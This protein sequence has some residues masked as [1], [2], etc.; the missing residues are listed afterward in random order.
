MPK[1]PP[2]LRP[3]YLSVFVGGPLKISAPVAAVA[4]LV[5]A[6]VPGLALLLAPA[7][8][9]SM[10][11]PALEPRQ[12]WATSTQSQVLAALATQAL[13]R[14]DPLQRRPPCQERIEEEINGVCWV[15]LRAQPPCPRGTWEHEGVCYGMALAPA[16][17]P[18]SGDFQP[19]AVADP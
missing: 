10:A 9:A 3:L 1:P 19:R 8:V 4:L 7:P 18:T 5:L 2:P 12:E 6:A 13:P 17:P 15:A 11:T 16:R 14:P